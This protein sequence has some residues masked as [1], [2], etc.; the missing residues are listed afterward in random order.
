MKQSLVCFWAR[1]FTLT[2]SVHPGVQLVLGEFNAGDTPIC[3]W[4]S[5][6]SRG[7]GRGREVLFITLPVQYASRK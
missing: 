7:W 6:P 4:T 1:H 2:V 5:I 3:T